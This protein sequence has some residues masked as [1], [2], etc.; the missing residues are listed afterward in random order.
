MAQTW[1]CSPIAHCLRRWIFGSH[2]G[3]QLTLLR[4]KPQGCQLYGAKT[5]TSV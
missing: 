4:Q 5:M 3:L 2:V 1:F